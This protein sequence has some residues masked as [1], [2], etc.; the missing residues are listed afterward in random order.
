MEYIKIKDRKII[1][2]LILAFVALAIF[3]ALIFIPQVRELLINIAEKIVS[4]PLTHKVWSKRFVEWENVFLKIDAFFIF[5]FLCFPIFG[6]AKNGIFN[7][8]NELL[9][10]NIKNA[11]LPFICIFSV[12]IILL[13]TRIF[14]ISQKQSM[15]WDE[16]SS[17]SICNRNE[18]GIWGKIYELE[19]VYSG[20][21]L[22]EITFWDNASVK[23]ALND[24]WQMHKFN[25]DTP[26]T[27]F[28]YSLLRLCFAG[29]KSGN[30][31]YILWRGC[32][33]NLLFFIISFWFMF[34]LLRCF[35]KNYILVSICLLIAFLNPASL[36]LTVFLRPYELQQVFVIILTFYV[37]CI[38]KA[39][40]KNIQIETVKNFII[41]VFVLAFT[42][43]SA[44][45]NLILICLYGFAILVLCINKK[46]WNLLKF[47][48]L[49]FIFGIVVA[50]ILYFDYGN[51]DY[52]GAEAFS[53]LEGSAFVANLLA[54][55]NGI[56]KI[57]SENVFF[58]IFCVFVFLQNILIFANSIKN[59]NNF[60]LC[61]ILAINLIAFF[62]IFY[63]APIDLKT[64]RYVAPLFPIF[65]LTFVNFKQNLEANI[66]I[67]ST[68]ALILVLSL[69]Q[70][71][72]KKSVVEHL[73]DVKIE[74]YKEIK[75]NN[76][77]IFVRGSLK[78][79]GLYA[80]LIPYFNDQSK[81]IFIANFEKIEEKY[82]EYLPCLFINQIDE[83]NK[84]VE[85][86][87]EK[88]GA[89]KINSII[90]HDIY[91]LEK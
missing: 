69:I 61:C 64:L 21:E 68:V 45:F 12:F 83:P 1:K 59:K 24:V 71:N 20:K 52:R 15:H 42:M 79:A 67:S 43:L 54:V 44:Y 2:N 65:A 30:L 90:S 72:G 6:K 74:N 40:E 47:F 77:P 60:S 75:E 91:L 41:G 84:K 55:K 34:L 10:L 63:F 9:N 48:L 18:Y 58:C 46:D 80:T 11:K 8:K 13:G 27:N 14:Y 26:H 49:M 56:V 25:N 82:L 23:D 28:Y 35:T 76:L 62:A 70:F 73:D 38:F 3:S 29:V 31:Q 57:L 33:L 51:M 50:K 16:V 32:L 87:S 5:V 39:K 19:K 4:K 7:V 66:I 78:G 53:K 81:I 17:I 88:F 86:E 89:K 36:S 22:K 85:I 37:T